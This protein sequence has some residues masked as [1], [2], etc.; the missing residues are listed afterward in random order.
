LNFELYEI[1]L[2]EMLMIMRSI[3]SK[4]IAPIHM[5]FPIY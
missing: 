4:W 2:V 1:P 5:I 3:I